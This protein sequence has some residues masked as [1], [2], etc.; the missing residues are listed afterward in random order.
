M[1]KIFLEARCKNKFLLDKDN[2][3]V[4][5]NNVGLCSSVQFLDSLEE[6]KTQIEEAGKK[7]E[8]IKGK[9]SKHCG[10][11][12][13]CDVLQGLDKYDVDC[14]LYIGDGLFHPKALLL[15]NEK[16]VF[17]YNPFT[18][19]IKHISTQDIERLKKKEKAALVKFYSSKEIG[20]IVTTKPGQ[21]N[22]K[23][24]QDLEEKYPDK[25]FYIFMCDTIDFIQLENFP[26][27]ECWVNTA[28]PR[29]SYD[30]MME[31]EKTIVDVDVVNHSMCIA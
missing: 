7:V 22:M 26:F 11:I 16:D 31:M 29:I 23:K 6:I 28:C 4:L 24:A 8:L 5:P 10:Q 15:K 2:I 14:F 20:V 21:Y 3:A 13:G 18:K 27:I 12:L 9:H 19:E 17:S 25:K 30:D 1:K